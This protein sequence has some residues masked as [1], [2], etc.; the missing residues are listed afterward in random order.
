METNHLEKLFIGKANRQLMFE[1]RTYSTEEKEL[2][3]DEMLKQVHKAVKQ[4]KNLVL[5]GTLYKNETRKKLKK[6]SRTPEASFLLRS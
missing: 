1:Y 4:N 3:C 5:D 6:S 2:V